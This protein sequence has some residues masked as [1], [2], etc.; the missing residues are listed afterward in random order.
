MSITNMYAQADV[1]IL[2][3]FHDDTRLKKMIFVLRLVSLYVTFVSPCIRL[4]N[5]REFDFCSNSA[6]SSN[7]SESCWNGAVIYFLYSCE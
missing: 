5:C 4:T 6:R 3:H 7:S 1:I 2:S